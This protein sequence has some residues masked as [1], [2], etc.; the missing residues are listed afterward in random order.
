MRS[1]QTMLKGKDFETARSSMKI[2]TKQHVVIPAASAPNATTIADW[3]KCTPEYAARV[4]DRFSA[5]YLSDDG[6]VICS[7]KIA[8]ST[9]S[10]DGTMLVKDR[11]SVV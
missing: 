10:G 1:L 8:A 3:L 6:N 4:R 9:V 5:S 7:R 2:G 11:K